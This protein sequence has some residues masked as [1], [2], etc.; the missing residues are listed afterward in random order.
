MTMNR[1]YDDLPDAFVMRM[2]NWAASNSGVVGYATSAAF[3]MMRGGGYRTA[4]TPLMLGEAEDTGRALSR[5]P[6][7]YRQAVSLF[8]QYEGRSRNWLASRC[9]QGVDRRT[10]ER[11]VIHGHSELRKEI[12]RQ[13]EL[14]AAYRAGAQRTQLNN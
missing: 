6:V 3:S 7:R 5:L 2:R 4:A 1:V 14:F 13:H 10:F 9:G 11:N 8:W 12:A